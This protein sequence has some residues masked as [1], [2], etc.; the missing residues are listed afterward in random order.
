MDSFDIFKKL[1]VGAKF[2]KPEKIAIKP[3]VFIDK[4]LMTM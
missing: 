2:K 4:L 1:S 3:E